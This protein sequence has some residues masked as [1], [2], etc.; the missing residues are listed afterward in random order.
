MKKQL[1]IVFVSMLFFG[2]C[3]KNEIKTIPGNSPGEDLTINTQIKE[4]YI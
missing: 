2:A 3:Q 4:N 1:L